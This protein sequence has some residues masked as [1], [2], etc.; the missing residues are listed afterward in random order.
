MFPHYQQEIRFAALSLNGK[1]APSY[2]EC[3]LVLK[4]M[5]IAARTSVFWENTVDFCNRVC[6]K[7][8]APIPP[9]YRAAWPMRAKLASAKGEQ[10]LDRQ[11][12]LEEFSRILLDGERFVEVN[13]YGPFNRHSFDRLLI[14]T[15]TKPADHAMISGIRDVIRQDGLGI[16]V[17]EHT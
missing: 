17:E 11:T 13:I 3:S 8:N 7:Q 2:G 14:R 6:P 4:S 10:L 5:A 16:T 15:S 9:G 1:G 12:T